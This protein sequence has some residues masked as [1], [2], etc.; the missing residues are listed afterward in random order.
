MEE[1]AA[2]L[3]EV[4]GT[5]IVWIDSCGSGAAI[6]DKD[7]SQ[8]GDA[9]FNDAVI[10]A[11]SAHDP[12]VV[13]SA[14]TYN[15]AWQTE[16]ETLDIDETAAF[17]TG[18][19]R[20]PKFYVLTASRYQQESWSGIYSYFTYYIGEGIGVDGS[21]PADANNDGL[22]TQ[23]ELFS[24]IKTSEENENMQQDVQAYPMNSDYVLFKR[25]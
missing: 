19:F 18:E 1:L 24:F 10:R 20:Q 12:N 14:D 5:V 3:S 9:V 2:A 13:I 23:R 15:S 17:E 16:N 11:F 21:L 8:N 7:V 25:R 6:Y 4:K 22:L